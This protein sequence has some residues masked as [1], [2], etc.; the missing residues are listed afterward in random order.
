MCAPPRRG[1]GRWIMAHRPSMRSGKRAASLSSG[2]I[3]GPSRLTVRKSPRHGQRDERSAPAVRRVRDRPF[4]ALRQPRQARVL[5][6]PDLLGVALDIGAEQRLGIE[7]PA[8]D[9]IGA[10][11]DVEL[12]DAA[13]VLD[14]GQQDGLVADARRSGVERRVGRVRDVIRRQDRILRPTVGRAGSPARSSRGRGRQFASGVGRLVGG[15]S[16][17][18]RRGRRGSVGAHVF[19]ERSAT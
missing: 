2:G 13:Q 8:A 9:T 12:G 17:R 11:R 3:T 19:D 4:L 10:A 5:A 18:G 16:R 15:L 14:P 6:A 7:P 1:E